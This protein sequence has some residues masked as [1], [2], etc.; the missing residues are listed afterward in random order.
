MSDEQ[1]GIDTILLAS[2]SGTD[3][4]VLMEITTATVNGDRPAK[5]R[6]LL[7][8]HGAA[9]FPCSLYIS[10]TIVPCIYHTSFDL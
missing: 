5:L 9:G 8:I 2:L 3:F 4:E 6:E 7:E 1:H 10:G